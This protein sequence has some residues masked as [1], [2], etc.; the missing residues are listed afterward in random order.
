VEDLDEQFGH[1]DKWTNYGYVFYYQDVLINQPVNFDLRRRPIPPAVQTDVDIEMVSKDNLFMTEKTTTEITSGRNG[2]RAVTFNLL[3]GRS[4]QYKRWD[5][6]D[7]PFVVKSVKTTS[8]LA[9]GYSHKYDE[10][11]VLLPQTLMAGQK[12][13]LQIEA[14]GN[15]LKNYDGDSYLVLG[16][17]WYFPQMGI[18]SMRAPFHSIVKVKDPYIPLGCGVNL[19]RWK[20]DDLN[21]VETREVKPMAFPFLVVGKFD[22]AEEQ[23]EGYDL[24]VYSY[25][26]SKRRGAKALLRNGLA[27]LDFFSNGMEPFPY[28]ELEV[29]EIPYYRHFFWQAPAGLV[30]I[31]SEGL[32][33]IGGDDSDLDTLI[34][35]YARK[36]QNARYAHEIA[37]QWFGNL[38]SF[39]T[40]YDNW[41][42]ESFAEYLSYM[43]MAE[44][45]KEKRK[46]KIQLR[47]WQI[48]AEECSDKSS[49]YGAGSLGGSPATER[50]YTQ[51]LY[52]KGPYVLHGLRQ[53]IGDDNFKKLFYFVTTQAAKKE[54]MKV[55][56]EDIILFVNHLTG[57]DYH[58]WFDRYIFG[59]ETPKVKL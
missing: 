46:A 57:K 22:V 54:D 8:G 13:S 25:A 15:L 21:C 29:V 31:T 16:N 32:N 37:H 44:G 47:E 9:L 56:T 30:E 24:K 26:M 49:V 10:L 43:F 23:K 35:R 53:E 45:A 14:E 6:R 51:L 38:V 40:M 12:I 17:M 28:K 50:C 4:E 52:G 2:L 41:L 48:D 58:E 5:E 27:I 18:L 19:R 1:W 36:G 20:E 3:N 39:A 33:P 59:T 42:S 55:I 34:K 11:L 7:D